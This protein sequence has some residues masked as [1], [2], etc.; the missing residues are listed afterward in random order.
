MRELFTHALHSVKV[1]NLPSHSAQILLPKC[2]TE[3]RKKDLL[4]EAAAGGKVEEDDWLLLKKDVP[5]RCSRWSQVCWLLSLLVSD[6]V[7]DETG[8]GDLLA[9]RYFPSVSRVAGREG[10]LLLILL[11]RMRKDVASVGSITATE[12]GYGCRGGYS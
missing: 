6:A 9:S 5:A 1:I 7:A 3:Q 4:G 2:T 10:W 11:L 12:E 8:N